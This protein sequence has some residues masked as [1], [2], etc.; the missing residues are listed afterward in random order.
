MDELRRESAVVMETP[1]IRKQ[2]LQQQTECC[3]RSVHAKRGR[4][5]AHELAVT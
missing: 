2:Q 3:S 5:A 4:T 1:P